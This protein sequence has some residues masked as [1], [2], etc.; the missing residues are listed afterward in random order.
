MDYIYVHRITVC[1]SI[2]SILTQNSVLLL[3]KKNYMWDNYKLQNVAVDYGLD[4][5]VIYYYITLYW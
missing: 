1:Y 5:F 2:C 3:Q 4:Y